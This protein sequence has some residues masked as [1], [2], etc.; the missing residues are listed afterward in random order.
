M[1]QE[2]GKK[3]AFSCTLSVLA[4]IFWPK[5]VQT[6]KHYKHS[7]FSGNNPKLKMTFFFEKGV[8]FLTLVK[9]WVLLTVFLKSCVLLK[10][11]N[12]AVGI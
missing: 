9:K 7:G 3:R 6:R 12:T 5:T 11:K 8:F 2:G 10:Q 4:K 1:C